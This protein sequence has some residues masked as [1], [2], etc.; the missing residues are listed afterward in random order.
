MIFGAFCFVAHC[1]VLSNTRSIVIVQLQPEPADRKLV[2]GSAW[3][4]AA[5]DES[6]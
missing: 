3:T 1:T 5:A 6:K 4:A 2:A